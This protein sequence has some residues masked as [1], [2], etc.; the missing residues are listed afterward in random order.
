LALHPESKELWTVVN[1]RD[2][3]GD[4]LVPDYLAK[5]EEGAF[6]GWP[7]AYSGTLPDPN[8]AAKRPDQV[9][10]SR[11]GD[12]LFRPH[13]APLGLAFYDGTSFP[14]EYRGDAFVALHGSWNSAKPVGYMVVRVPF[15]GGK[16]IGG[17][18]VFATGFRIGGPET[19]VVWGRP[20][21]LA[22]AKDGSLLIADDTSNR[23][24][25]V[26]YRR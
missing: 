8:F 1:E 12:V 3:M 9:A 22:V 13:S 23:I 2:G 24:F 6:F 21:G 11:A 19:A 5:V 7:Y 18:E 15:E 4:G 10:K 17:Y 14:E 26:S 25:R 16:P 20:T